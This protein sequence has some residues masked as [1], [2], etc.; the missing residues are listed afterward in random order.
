MNDAAEIVKK[1]LEEKGIETP[2]KTSGFTD[3]GKRDGIE[4]LVKEVLVLLGLDLSDDSLTDTPKRVAKMYVDEIFSG[5]SYENFPKITCIDNKMKVDQM[6]CVNKIDVSSTCEHHLIT[7]DGFASVAYIPKEKVIGL[8]K[9]NRIVEFFSKRPQVQER[10][11][12]QVKE[13][14]VALLETEN[15]AVMVQAKH[16]C[17]KSRGVRDTASETT[18]SALGGVFLNDAQARNEFYQMVSK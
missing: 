12:Q 15:V 13:A 8:S 7:I 16:Y 6:V 5:L 1:A 11:T 14:L 4:R 2:L 3:D 18:T 9:I 17:V 10:L